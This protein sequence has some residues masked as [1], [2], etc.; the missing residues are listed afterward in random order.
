MLITIL[1]HDP[2]EGTLAINSEGKKLYV[3]WDSNTTKIMIRMND[4]ELAG[5]TWEADIVHDKILERSKYMIT[6]LVSMD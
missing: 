4:S 5:S 2:K 6:K 3:D 1:P